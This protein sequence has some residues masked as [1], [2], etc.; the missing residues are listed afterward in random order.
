M[1][2]EQLVVFRLG[3][4]EYAVPISK[5]REVVQYE[6]A[7]K[8]PNIPDY[9]E[10]VINLRGKIIPVVDLAIKFA[11]SER[12]NADECT[13]IL[14]TE[15]GE[16]A[17]I[18]DEVTEVATLPDSAIEPVP[19]TMASSFLRGIGKSGERLLII[20][21]IEKIFAQEDFDFYNEAV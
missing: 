20:L 14:E 7:T 1:S 17:V 2:E 4:E 11:L 5:V 21:D 19:D 6:G 18:V 12:E 3:D 9:M 16:V 8:I 13:V 10:G 15:R